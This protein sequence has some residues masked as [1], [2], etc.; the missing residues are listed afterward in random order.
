M[1]RFFVPVETLASDTPLLSGEV[2]HQISRVLRMRAGEHVILLDGSGSEVEVELVQVAGR[3][4]QAAVRQRRAALGEP[5]VQVTLYQCL[6]K[7]DNFEWVLQKGTE[8]G[9]TRFV[10]LISQRTVANDLRDVSAGKLERWRH[11]L[12][13]AAE[14]SR[15][16]QVP[17][18]S[19][20][21]RL[22]T[23]LLQR[24]M[25][26]PALLFWEGPGPGLYLEKLLTGQQR[27]E[28]RL[29]VWIG[30]E[31][32]F[33]EDEVA[34]ACSS[35]VSIASLGRRILRAE[36]AAVTALALVLHQSGEMEGWDAVS[37]SN[38]DR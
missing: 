4:C 7:K 38:S 33:A 25:A 14:Q 29:S 32:G 8:L 18:L 30:P 10:P 26:V 12:R 2:A 31:G 24:E 17:E 28:R 16:G 5:L 11:I 1:H 3:Q 21:L 9:A 6:L 36:T 15:R 19:A 23:A 27:S 35:G 37:D 22:E 13:E 34:R 20:P